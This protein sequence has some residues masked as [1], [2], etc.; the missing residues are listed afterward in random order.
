MCFRFVLKQTEHNRVTA[1][2]FKQ[3]YITE[4]DSKLTAVSTPR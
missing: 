3:Y 2:S 4:N 1:A